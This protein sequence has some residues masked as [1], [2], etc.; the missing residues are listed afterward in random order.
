MKRP[1]LHLPVGLVD[2]LT[3]CKES[4]LTLHCDWDK[5]D[6]AVIADEASQSLIEE[7]VLLGEV[8]LGKS[9]DKVFQVQHI[10]VVVQA[11][12]QLPILFYK[13]NLKQ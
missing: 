5:V 7:F 1:N 13:V 8:V 9:I 6:E 11:E 2:G 4:L 3:S 10:S 12:L